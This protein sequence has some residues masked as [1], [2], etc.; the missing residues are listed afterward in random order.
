MP[1][2]DE[3]RNK[4]VEG[5]GGKNSSRQIFF[6]PLG[7]S[8]ATPLI[9]TPKTKISQCTFSDSNLNVNLK[10][11]IEFSSETRF[12][13]GFNSDGSIIFWG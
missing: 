10:V 13:S 9:G 6:A 4:L 12:R 1:N 11:Y 5:R 2:E 3:F 7:K 8:H